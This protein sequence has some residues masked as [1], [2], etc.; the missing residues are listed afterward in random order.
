MKTYEYQL[1]RSVV[2]QVDQQ[3]KLNEF[4]AQGWQ[5]VAFIYNDVFVLQ[6]AIVPES[7][8]A[9]QPLRKTK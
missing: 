1:V 7:P 3:V 9:G 4:G 6:R 5:V 8:K 2:S